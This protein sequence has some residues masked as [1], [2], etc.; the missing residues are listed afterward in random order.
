MG[1][2][3][4]ERFDLS[5]AG[6]KNRIVYQFMSKNRR[7]LQKGYVRNV[8]L[9][10]FKAKLSLD[11]AGSIHNNSISYQ[12]KLQNVGFK[13]AT[14]WDRTSFFVG[15]SN[16]K[17]GHNPKIDPVTSF[18][19]NSL[20]LDI[21]FTQD[22]GVHFKT[23]I[24]QK[25]DFE[26]AIYTGGILSSPL[27]TYAPYTDGENENNNFKFIKPAYKGSWLGTF[28]VGSPAFKSFEYGAI[29]LL[30]KNGEGMNERHIARIGFDAVKKI[31]EKVKFDSQLHGGISTYS[32]RN[33]T[34]DVAL[35]SNVEFYF[36]GMFIISTSNAI[37]L[38]ITDDENYNGTKGTAVNSLSYVISPHTRIRLNQFY[39]YGS[40]RDNKGGV[41]I[42][43]TTGI[44]KR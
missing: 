8:A 17:F 20:K 36:K 10:G 4:G 26:A 2:Q 1:Y 27:V 35:Q 12:L 28:R 40:L 21:G 42:Q 22:L 6:P 37:L 44:G 39:N 16:I 19:A 43:L 41:S 33:N 14:K 23:A 38:A 18:T 25:Y 34:F 24:S 7:L 9:S 30:G 15:Y 31:Q 32:L 13:F 5:P 11:A 29:A 3:I